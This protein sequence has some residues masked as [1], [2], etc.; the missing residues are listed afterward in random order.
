MYFS[1]NAHQIS[2]NVF[3]TESEFRAKTYLYD[4]SRYRYDESG[5]LLEVINAEMALDILISKEIKL[6]KPRIHTHDGNQNIW[7]AS[8]D[9]GVMHKNNSLV[10]VVFLRQFSSCF[11]EISFR[12]SEDY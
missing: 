5:K 12:T 9:I 4:F 3:K 2:Q 6:M 10:L 8:A 11:C 7:V 1:E